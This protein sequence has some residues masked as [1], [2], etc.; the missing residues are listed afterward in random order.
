MDTQPSSALALASNPHRHR[1]LWPQLLPKAIHKPFDVGKCYTDFSMNSTVMEDVKSSANGFG[2]RNV[3]G[4]TGT[5]RIYSYVQHNMHSDICDTSSDEGEPLQTPVSDSALLVEVAFNET[6]P[7]I[8]GDNHHHATPGQFSEATQYPSSARDSFSG[9]LSSPPKCDTSFSATSFSVSPPLSFFIPSLHSSH[10]SAS[11]SSASS[12]GNSS[13]LLFASVSSSPSS[14][15]HFDSRAFSCSSP[16][17]DSNISFEGGCNSLD[18]YPSSL[19][20]SSPSLPS[21][22]NLVPSQPS[23]MYPHPPR[24]APPLVS[25]SPLAQSISELPSPQQEHERLSSQQLPISQQGPP[26]KR[27]PITEAPSGSTRVVQKPKLFRSFASEFLPSM[28]GRSY[29]SRFPLNH[30]LRPDFVR[31]Y[32]LDGELGKGGYGFVMAARHRRE[33]HEVA[34]KFI[35]KNRIPQIGWSVDD[36]G[37]NVPKEARLLSQLSH[38]GIVKFYDLFEDD[39]FFYLVCDSSLA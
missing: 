37:R 12:A 21:P 14:P 4:G 6:S 26:C 34:V 1:R 28:L 27:V 29:S 5:D 16:L 33:G 38:P 19:D 20:D 32:A 7:K 9:S 18:L 22:S 35:M 17:L 31:E 30:R 10:P 2:E 24:H 36:C 8:N 23:S 3:G 11:L 13:G 15:S 39:I 25:S